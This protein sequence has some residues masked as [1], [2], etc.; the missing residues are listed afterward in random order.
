MPPR[1]ANITLRV[2][3]DTLM[4]VRARAGLGRT[5]VNALIRRFLDEY[6]AVPAAWREGLPPP[7]TPDGRMAEVMDPVGAGHRPAAQG[8]GGAD[9]TSM[10]AFEA[11]LL[12]R[13][14]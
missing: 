5:S 12:S 4:W 10:E 2:D 13:Q 3:L 7:W 9:S 1:Q 11:E 8:L 14:E 6:A